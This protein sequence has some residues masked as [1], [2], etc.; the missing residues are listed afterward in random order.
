MSRAGVALHN[1]GKREKLADWDV[2]TLLRRNIDGLSSFLQS[3]A[4][5]K[6]LALSFSRMSG[7]WRPALGL[8]ACGREF[9]S[10]CA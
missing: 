8:L 3:A 1:D 7:D 4:T 2:E 9:N 5:A 10:A 6:N